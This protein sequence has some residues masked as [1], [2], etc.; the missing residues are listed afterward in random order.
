MG[1][2]TMLR[3]GGLTVACTAAVGAAVVVAVQRASNQHERETATHAT[4]T[5]IWFG[6]RS[7]G[8][9]GIALIGK[10]LVGKDFAD[11]DLAADA[12]RS[13]GSAPHAILRNQH[14]MRYTVYAVEPSIATALPK[15]GHA[16]G[17][18]PVT[19][20]GRLSATGDADYL[21]A[22]NVEDVYVQSGKRL[23]IAESRPLDDMSG[24]Y[25]KVRFHAVPPD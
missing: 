7:Q 14:T 9:D 16:A 24:Y 22:G 21:D 19:L 2:G 12:A 17:G 23:F 1:I 15:R 20:D 4:G 10:P 18:L 3:Y 5:G 25:D 8:T 6:R 11:L 13:L